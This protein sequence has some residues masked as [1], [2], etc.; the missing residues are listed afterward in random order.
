MKTILNVGD[1]IRLV[2]KTR[3]AKNRINENCANVIVSN[4]DGVVLAKKVC[5]QHEDNMEAWRWFDVV[6]DIDWDWELR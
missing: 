2:P 5:V 1:K 4:L 6:D 3:H